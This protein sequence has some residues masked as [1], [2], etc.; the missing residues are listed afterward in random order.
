MGNKEEGPELRR[1]PADGE[2]VEEVLYKVEGGSPLHHPI[3]CSLN[4]KA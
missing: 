1:A 4:K 3:I 2:R